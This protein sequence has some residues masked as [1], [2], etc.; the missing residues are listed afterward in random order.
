MFIDPQA[1]WREDI[2]SRTM[3]KQWREYAKHAWDI[4]PTLG[5][6]C[7]FKTQSFCVWSFRDWITLLV[8]IF[9][10]DVPVAYPLALRAHSFISVNLE[11]FV[12]WDQCWESKFFQFRIRIQLGVGL[13][14]DTRSFLNIPAAAGTV[15]IFL[16]KKFV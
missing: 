13:A 11:G 10:W 14:T 12:S 8:V 15:I 7:F 1:K 16:I 2:Q 5:R 3:E 9:S 6:S 4:A